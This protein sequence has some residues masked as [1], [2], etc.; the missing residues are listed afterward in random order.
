MPAVETTTFRARRTF[1]RF[2]FPWVI[3]GV[4]A[5]AMACIWLWPSP[6]LELLQRVNSTSFTLM[7]TFLFLAAWLLFFSGLR[8]ALRFGILLSILVAVWAAVRDVK[9][10]GDMVPVVRFR[11]DP[12][13]DA[14]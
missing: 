11:W 7:L 3:L 1:F 14:I 12:T 9:F 5:V 6:S 8:W 2:W 13:R 10:T 4:A